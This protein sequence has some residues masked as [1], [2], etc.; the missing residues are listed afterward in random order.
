MPRKAL[1]VAHGLILHAGERTEVIC[2]AISATRALEVEAK[3]ITMQHAATQSATHGMTHD[4]TLQFEG[5]QEQLV[6]KVNFWLRAELSTIT[7]AS[8]G[9]AGHLCE[10]LT[11]P[12]VC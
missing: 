11:P 1:T 3:N 6:E 4:M 7:F 2:D 9:L 12:P 8:H 10:R 5:M